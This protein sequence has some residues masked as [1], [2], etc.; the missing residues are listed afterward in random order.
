[1][2]Q[3]HVDPR[4]ILVWRMRLTLAAL[5]PS[6]CSSLFFPVR[7]WI[8]TVFTG[9][10][11][12][13]YLFLFIIYYPIK[14][15]KLSFY[16]DETYLVI[17]CGVFYTR[18]KAIPLQNLQYVTIQTGPLQGLFRVKT[19]RFLCAGGRVYLPCVGLKDAQ[20]FSLLVQE[21]VKREGDFA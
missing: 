17:H 7:N 11:A 9:L 1:M 6:F 19:V 18:T 21:P 5:V 2:N 14:Y 13:I 20:R 12:G 4:A 3:H 8:W 10:W 15:K 16:L